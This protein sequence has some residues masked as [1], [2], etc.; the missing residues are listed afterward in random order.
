MNEAGLLQI[1]TC[2]EDSHYQFERDETND[3]SI[4]WELA[5]VYQQR[6]PVAA[7]RGD[8]D[9][10]PGLNAI[11]VWCLSQLISNAASQNIR[12]PIHPMTDVSKTK[13]PKERKGPRE[14]GQGEMNYP[15]K[16]K[17]S[18]GF[19]KTVACC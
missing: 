4:A 7:G 17:G 2:G 14:W 12:P 5:A 1:L 16:A 18:K 9:R 19:N 11:G 15:Q 10:V 3:D 8:S 13:V 6:R